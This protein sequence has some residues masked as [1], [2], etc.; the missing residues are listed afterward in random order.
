MIQSRLCRIGEASVRLC[1]QMHRVLP[2]LTDLQ[3]EALLH[4]VESFCC[5][6]IEYYHSSNDIVST[7]EEVTLFF[8]T[9]HKAHAVNLLCPRG[10]PTHDN[11]VRIIKTFHVPQSSAKLIWD[12]VYEVYTRR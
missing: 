1:E 3:L 9:Y 7:L 8:D 11:V 2:H 4:R 6:Q 12:V 10:E 5:V